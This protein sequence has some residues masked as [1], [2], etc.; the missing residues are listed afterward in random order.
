MNNDI[1]TGKAI[2]MLVGYVC[3]ALLVLAIMIPIIIGAFLINPALGILTLGIF[4]YFIK[5]GAKSDEV[6]VVEEEQKIKL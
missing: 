1:S 3:A 4:I 5:E 6:E 2:L